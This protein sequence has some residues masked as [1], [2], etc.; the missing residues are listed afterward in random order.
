MIIPYE[1]NCRFCFKSSFSTP[2]FCSASPV[3]LFTMFTRAINFNNISIINRC[4][5]LTVARHYAPRRREVR[6]PENPGIDKRLKHFKDD[7]AQFENDP[8]MFVSCF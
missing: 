7:I 5:Q 8:E 6:V 4:C 2:R 1:N 3:C